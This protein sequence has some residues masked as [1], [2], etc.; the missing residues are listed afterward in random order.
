MLWTA[1]NL[2]L[3]LQVS[4]WLRE[5]FSRCLNENRSLS[6]SLNLNPVHLTAHWSSN[7][8][9]LVLLCAFWIA[10]LHFWWF[11]LWSRRRSLT[12]QCEQNVIPPPRKRVAVWPSLHTP[13]PAGNLRWRIIYVTLRLM[14]SSCQVLQKFSF[15]SWLFLSEE[16]RN[17]GGTGPNWIQQ[18]QLNQH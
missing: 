17:T 15:M 4:L 5:D 9:T 11:W 6:V 7:R 3:S 2:P 1:H 16:G 13:D 10:P 12:Y 18:T 8:D 14:T